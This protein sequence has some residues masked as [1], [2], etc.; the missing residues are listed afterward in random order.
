MMRLSSL[1]FGILPGKVFFPF[2]YV[3]GVIQ[4]LYD[5]IF[6]TVLLERYRSLAPMYYRGAAAAIVVYD[7]TKKVRVHAFIVYIYLIFY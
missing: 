7:I 3:L 4:F 5:I 1:K 6:V 2:R